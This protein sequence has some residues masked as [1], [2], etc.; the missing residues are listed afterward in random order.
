MEA[1][2]AKERQREAGQRFGRGVDSSHYTRNIAA[3]FVRGDLEGRGEIPHVEERRDAAG[4][5]A[6][7]AADFGN[8]PVSAA[9]YAG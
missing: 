3:D 4:R 7:D 9:V 8:V 1:P 5:S 2:A 6:P